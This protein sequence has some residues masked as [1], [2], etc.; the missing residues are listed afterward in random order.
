MIKDLLITVVTLVVQIILI[1]LWIPNK[2]F[3]LLYDWLYQEETK[4]EKPKKVKGN[5]DSGLNYE[6][7][8]PKV[9]PEGKEKK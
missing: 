7:T 2:L 1:V 5:N 4:I 8:K 6:L 3:H 9:I